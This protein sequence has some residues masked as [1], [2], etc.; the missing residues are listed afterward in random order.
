MTDHSNAETV[1]DATKSATD[2]TINAVED[3][4]ERIEQ[5][6]SRGAGRARQLYAAV[7]DSS[8]ARRVREQLPAAALGFTA[9]IYPPAAV[10]IVAE[11]AANAAYKAYKDRP[12]RADTPVSNDGA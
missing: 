12:R 8:E 9:A 3:T 4:T 1:R 5:T 10:G 11:R 6:A 7:R 2:R